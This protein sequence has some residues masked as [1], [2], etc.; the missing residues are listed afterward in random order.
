[1]DSSLDGRLISFRTVAAF[2]IGLN[3]LRVGYLLES[4]GGDLRRVRSGLG[5]HV[6][7]RRLDNDQSTHSATFTTGYRV[8]NYCSRIPTG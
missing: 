2:F 7:A 4:F 3:Y 5:F 8:M 1:M 6:C